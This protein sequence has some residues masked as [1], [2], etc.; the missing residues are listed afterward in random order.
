MDNTDIARVLDEIADWLELQDANP[1]RM[2]AYRNAARLLDTMATRASVRLK[3]GLQVDRRVVPTASFGADWLY[4]T[5]SKAHNIAW[6]RLAQRHGLTI[7]ENGT[8]RG[9]A[10]L[11]GR[12]EVDVFATVGLPDAIL[13]R[14]DQDD[15]G[16][17][18]AKAEG[19]LLSIASDAHGA[20]GF[21]HLRFGIGQAR[22]G[23][24]QAANVL[25][26]RP[27]AALR[28]LLA[29]TM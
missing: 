27:R 3:T 21:D 7:N 18:A 5:G 12:H 28:P 26:V 10:L 22:R 16:C 23:W 20:T 2:R 6:R 25:N 15:A 19:L 29:R 24:L 8:F 9:R 1:L 14:L 13:R 4:F 17:L 11:A